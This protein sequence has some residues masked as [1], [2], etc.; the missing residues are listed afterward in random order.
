MREQLGVVFQRGNLLAYLNVAENI[1]F[2][3]Q[4]NG[5]RKKK[6]NQRVDELLEQVGLAYAKT[7]L[8]HELSGGELQRASIAR[9]LAHTPSLLLADEPTASLDS[10]AGAEVISLISSLT[11]EHNCTTIFSTHDTEIIS[12]ADTVFHLHDGRLIE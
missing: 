1:S 9:A 11:R 6:Q 5:M 12:A 7:A 3:L 4:L 8:P 2:P 10:I